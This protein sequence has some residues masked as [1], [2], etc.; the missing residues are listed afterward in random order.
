MI[1]T[2]N[3]LFPSSFNLQNGSEY[4]FKYNSALQ[5]WVP[6]FIKPIKLNVKDIGTN[7]NAVSAPV[8]EVNF[9]NANWVANFTLPSTANDRDRILV[10]STAT[11]T[12]KINNTNINSSASLMLKTGDQYEFMYVSDKGHWV[13]MSAP[14]KNIES[15]SNIASVLPNMT[16]PKRWIRKFEQL[17]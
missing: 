8:T 10:K 16:E 4:W 13:L 7:L 2:N 1:A 11:W 5:K 12:A 17:L 6:E 14:I 3:L 15:T 9:A